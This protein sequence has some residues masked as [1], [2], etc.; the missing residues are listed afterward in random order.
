MTLEMDGELE[1]SIY[2]AAERTRRDPAGII[3]MRQGDASALREIAR[4]HL[5]DIAGE[6]A[7][8]RTTVAHVAGAAEAMGPE[9]V[10]ELGPRRKVQTGKRGWQ[11]EA[12]RLKGKPCD[13][14]VG[15]RGIC[16]VC[17]A[18]RK[19]PR[20]PDP[21]YDEEA[22]KQSRQIRAGRVAYEID[23]VGYSINGRPLGK[24][25]RQRLGIAKKT[26]P[27]VP[28]PRFRQGD[29]VGTMVVLYASPEET[30]FHRLR[31]FSRIPIDQLAALLYLP[32]S[33]VENWLKNANPHA[34]G[35]MSRETLR[36]FIAAKMALG[37]ALLQELDA[38]DEAYLDSLKSGE[39]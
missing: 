37:T 6:A 3:A 7:C 18:R 36:K 16:I 21:H 38:I 30:F 29:E 28:I 34:F 8:H 24:V 13:E 26:P 11:P 19:P 32:R 31:T 23:G 12:C 25:S 35:A 22:L 20:D 5:R 15:K 1:A 4:Q 14:R 2:A 27:G 17:K 33:T 9:E 10:G 39:G